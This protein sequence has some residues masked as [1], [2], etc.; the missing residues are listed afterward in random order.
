MTQPPEVIPLGQLLFP[1]SLITSPL[2]WEAQTAGAT[3]EIPTGNGFSA[4]AWHDE[5]AVRLEVKG[6][7]HR[8]I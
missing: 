6:S 3:P 1:H 2:S 5:K 7:A 4:P 8:L